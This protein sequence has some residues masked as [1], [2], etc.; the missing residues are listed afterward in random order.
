MKLFILV[1]SKVVALILRCFPLKMRWAMAGF[2]AWLWWEVLR[3]RRFT[4]Y[5]NLSFVFPKMSK[6]EKQALAKI[7]L[8]NMCYNFVD[9]LLMPIFTKDY[10]QDKCIVHGLENYEKAQKE[11]KGVLFLSLHIGNGDV[12]MAMLALKGLPMSL[13]SKKMKNKFANEFW[14]GVRERMGNQFI[15]PHGSSTAF[16]ILKTL[17]RKQGV[18]FVIDQFMGRPYGIET[19]FFGRKTGTAYGLAL[20][21]LKTKAPV[22]PI[23]NYRDDQFRTHLVI[24]EEIRPTIKTEGSLSEDRDLQILQMTQEYNSVIESIVLKHPEQWMWVHRRWKRWE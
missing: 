6:S 16:D 24:G 4:V 23:Y 15:D 12:G 8:K 9:F 11:N 2:L 10:I 7:S 14:F 1:L 3:L 22:L 17:K 13:I 21:A 18:V 20:F 19:T 5:R